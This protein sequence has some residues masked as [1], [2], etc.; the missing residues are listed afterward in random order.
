MKI[1]KIFIPKNIFKYH[2]KTIYFEGILS[3]PRTKYCPTA[4]KADWIFLTDRRHLRPRYKKF[5]SKII[6]FDFCAPDNSPY[7][8]PHAIYFKHK[9][10]RKQGPE[11][12]WIN[13]PKP[14]YNIQHCLKNECLQFKDKFK[15]LREV[16]ISIFFNPSSEGEYHYRER[17]AQFIQEH[18]SEKYNIWVGVIGQ[19]G[20]EGRSHTQ[21]DYFRKMFQSK[22]VVTCGPNTWEGDYRLYEA[23]F[24]G[25]LVFSDKIYTQVIEPFINKRHLIYYERGNFDEL[26]KLIPYYLKHSSKREKIG[27]RGQKLVL[28]KHL[29]RN[30]IDEV[31]K[32]IQKR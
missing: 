18:F 14:V 25:A 17:L 27:S 15:G 3:H 32:V 23:L 29:P 8:Y 5:A 11:N 10:F 19:D 26:L 7:Q 21:D 9:M 16:D 2:T 1:I 31:L 30:R 6:I 4:K 13:Y 28:K 12:V 20:K 22:I 24:S